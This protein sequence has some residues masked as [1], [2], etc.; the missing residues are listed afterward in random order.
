[1]ELTALQQLVHQMYIAYY[2][3]PA[4]PEGLQYWVEQLEQNGDWTAVSAAFGAPENE[5]NQALYGELN[6]EQT[7]AA[8]YQS[9]FNREAVA[10]EVEFWAASEFSA[11]DLTFAI[12]NGAQNDDLATVNNKVEF[13]AELVAQ[14]ETNAAYAEL[15]DP[16]ALLTAVTSE[17]DVTA[18]YVSNAVAS[19][20]VGESFSLTAAADDRLFG[21]NNSDTFTAEAGTLQNGDQL[22]DPS[23]DDNDTLNAVINNANRNA[24]TTLVNIENV[25]LDLDVFSGAAFNAVNTEGA[26]ITASSDKLGYN[27]DFT[28]NNAGDNNVVAGENVTSLDIDGLEAGTVDAGAAE[29]V[30]VAVVDGDNA[31]VTVN[32]DIALTVAGATNLNLTAT[33]DS[34]VE[35]I[36]GTVDTIT[37]S[38]EGSITVQGDLSGV[39]DI[40]GVDAAVIDTDTNVNASD[41]EVNSI[42]VDVDLSNGL[43][44]ADAANV[45]IDEEQTGLTITGQNNN[46][47]TAN[48]SSGVAALGTLTFASLASAQLDLT[49]AGVEVASLDAGAVA[50]TVNV[51][52][53]AEIADLNG[54]STIELTGAGDVVV[55]NADGLSSLDASNLDGDLEVTTVAAAEINGAVGNNTIDFNADANLDFV[56]QAGDDSVTMGAVFASEANLVL[57][58]GDDTVTLEENLNGGAAVAIN[59]GEGNDTLVLE[60]G[61]NT[62][63]ADSLSLVGLETIQL[64]E[65]GV[66]DVDATV[67]ASQIS[68]AS[69]AVRGQGFDNSTLSVVE[70]TNNGATID[71]SSLDVSDSASSGASFAITGGNSAD[72]ITGTDLADT[73][74]GGEGADT[75]TGGAGADTFAF[76]ITADASTDSTAAS[77]DSITDFA[78]GTDEIQ[79]TN[80]ATFEVIDQSADTTISG[81]ANLGAA[82]AAAYDLAATAN[83]AG[84]EAIQFTYDSNTYFAVESLAAGDEL[85]ALVVDVTGVT[86]TV[87][88]DDFVV[89]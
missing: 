36:P 46:G 50:L 19:G 67:A 40:T 25:N 6:R 15:Q 10:E 64:A 21:T 58:S 87:T 61:V 79:F 39:S 65:E 55:E 85:G 74:T 43:T 76:G 24:E 31:N 62:S 73:I 27:G 26:T 33:A 20:K 66:T 70:T 22:L 52:D 8:I 51:T 28:L 63:A 54:T 71:L 23:A 1:M 60:A 18:E 12:I 82:V 34:V 38:G 88:A 37:G 86:G 59:F 2:Q 68:G 5:E 7:I 32:G 29:T 41:W 11:T 14:L 9:A 77:T 3:R 49:A 47:S 83:D 75:L 78:G 84:F 44:V 35:L 57:G 81:A 13:S 53:G 42:S 69:L 45:S 80:A 72:T 56:G 30:D 4:D 89:A 48:V 17:T 16:K